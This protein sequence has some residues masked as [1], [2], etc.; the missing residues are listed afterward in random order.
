MLETRESQRGRE[1]ERERER[2]R[3]GFH[4][5]EV[6]REI[7][8]FKRNELINSSSNGKGDKSTQLG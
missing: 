6:N 3:E 1:G 5:R 7:S 2:E 8:F 4:S